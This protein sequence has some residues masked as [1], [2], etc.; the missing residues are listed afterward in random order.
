M[1]QQEAGLFQDDYVLGHSAEEHERLRRQGQMLAP[2][3][4]RLFHAIGLQP[5]WRCL[6]W[7]VVQAKSCG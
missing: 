1:N 7:A 4:R 3:T 2:A 5:G 6:D